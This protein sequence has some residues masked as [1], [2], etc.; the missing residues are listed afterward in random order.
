MI[1]AQDRAGVIGSGGGMLWRVPADFRHFRAATTGCGVVMGRT[2]Y[3]SLT[4]ALK[5]RRNVVLS[6]RLP[7]APDGAL[8]ARSLPEA[9]A[10]AGQD[11][12][13]DARTTPVERSWPRVW[14]IGGG[15]V[16]AE[17]MG[18]G[19]AD[20]LVVTTVDL[21]AATGTASHPEAT[22]PEALVRAPGIDPARWVIDPA[23]SDPPGTWRERS[24]DATWRVDTWVHGR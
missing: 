3:T 7:E 2:T 19:V 17:A 21:G 18:S 14:V 6:R 5:R 20:T 8:L 16:Y 13:D 1:W 24:G 22:A 11:L 23:R 4:T 15:Q 10:L 9:L 12:P